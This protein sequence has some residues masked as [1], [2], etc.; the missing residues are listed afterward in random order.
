MSPELTVSDGELTSD[1]VRVTLSAGNL[2]PIAEAKPAWTAAL[3]AE[4]GC[5][6]MGTGDINGDWRSTSCSLLATPPAS[7]SELE[8]SP[9][10]SSPAHAR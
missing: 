7:L 3:E 6:P 2:A 5:D 10:R 4:V 9:R 8:A 1:P